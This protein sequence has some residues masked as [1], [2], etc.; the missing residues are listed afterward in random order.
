MTK[1]LTSLAAAAGFALAAVTPMALADDHKFEINGGL[2]YHLFDEDWEIEDDLFYGI[3]LGYVIDPT[4]TV[5]AWWLESGT[6]AEDFNIDVDLR[7]YRVDVLYHLVEEGDWRPFIVAGVGDMEFDVDGFDKHSGTRL[8]LGMGVKKALTER[9]NLRGDVRV[10][11]NIDEE[12]TD[13]AVMLALNYEIGGNY[14]KSEPAQQANDADG[15]GVEDSLD[16]CPGTPAGVAVNAQ[17]CPLDS[18]GDGVYDYMDK[19]PD[20]AAGLKV[21]TDGCPEKLEESVSITLKVHFDHDSA[22]VKERYFSDIK[23]VAD[24][25]AQYEGSV[26]E[27]GGHSDDRGSETYN[28]KLSQRRADSVAAVL[29]TEF[30]IAQERVTSKGYGEEGPVASNDTEEGREANRRVEAI[31]SSQ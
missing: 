31:I 6:E 21:D 9:L 23:R 14:S 17:G 20:T 10:L 28:Q 30:G 26:V 13:L 29:V 7:E 5:E 25:M 18:D 3:G 24:Y 8:N 19:C 2:G 22:V 1:T 27:I 4:W 12:M 15:D 11:N 16:Q